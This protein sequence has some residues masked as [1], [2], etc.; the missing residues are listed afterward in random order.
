LHK[1]DSGHDFSSGLAWEKESEEKNAFRGLERGAR[2]REGGRRR[3][4][5]RRRWRESV[6]AGRGEGRGKQAG[7]DNYP[8]AK[9]R[10]WLTAIEEWQGSNGGRGRGSVRVAA[11]ARAMRQGAAAAGLAGP[12]ARGGGFIGRPRGLG[13]RARGIAWA[14]VG[15][16]PQL[17]SSSN[18]NLA[19]GRRRAQ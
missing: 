6:A 7:E 2:A 4:A 19:R 9:L 11:L 8:K 12:R 13:V 16:V 5:A 15:L 3:G 1:R 18:P 17:D 10:W 14:E